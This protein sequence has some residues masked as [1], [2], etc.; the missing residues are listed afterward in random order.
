M[1]QNHIH[2]CNKKQTDK[3]TK[4]TTHVYWGQ[5]HRPGKRTV[6]TVVSLKFTMNR[7]VTHT[8]TD[9]AEWA[10]PKGRGESNKAK[11]AAPFKKREGNNHL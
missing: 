1:N 8:R 9:A 7:H 3:Q 6:E 10:M 5:T 11:P 2:S 4:R